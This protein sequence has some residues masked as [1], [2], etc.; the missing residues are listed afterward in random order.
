MNKIPFGSYNFTISFPCG[1]E[2][3]TKLKDAALAEVQKIIDNGPEEK[4]VNKVKEAQ[5]LEY[6]E[7]LKK[8]RYW[9]T[10]LKNADYN[11]SDRAKIVGLTKDIDAITG[12][13]IQKVA[14]KYLSGGHMLAVLYPEDKKE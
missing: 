10:S 2:N 4:D 5:L 7:S 6:K 8:N 14:K 12:A 1:P 13:D 9:L 11:K 3:V